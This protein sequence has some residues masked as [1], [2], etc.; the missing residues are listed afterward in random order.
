M[1]NGGGRWPA[2]D[3]DRSASRAGSRSTF[4]DVRVFKAGVKN[5]IALQKAVAIY[6]ELNS[7]HVEIPLDADYH[8]AI[9]GPVTVQYVETFD[10]G[11]QKLAEAKADLR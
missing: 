1:T 11:T 7:R 6:T 9:E 10:D 4:G 5:P 2:V 3:G 8:G